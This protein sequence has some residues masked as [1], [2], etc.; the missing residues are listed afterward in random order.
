MRSLE[1]SG[2]KHYPR[3]V[4]HNPRQGRSNSR[5]WSGPHKEQRIDIVQRS[6][7]SIG[8]REVTAN[9]FDFDG[10]IGRIRVASQGADSNI[11]GDQLRDDLAPYSTG[12]SDDEGSFH[13]RP[14]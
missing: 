5:S 1:R 9:D 6:I 4:P 2:E 14:A 11:P 3:D 7:E 10:Q 8:D 12:G 13:R